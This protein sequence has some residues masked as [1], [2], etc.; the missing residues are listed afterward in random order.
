MAAKNTFW[1][2]GETGAGGLAFSYTRNA[3]GLRKPARKGAGR[4]SSYS[5]LGEVASVLRSKGP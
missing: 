2:S 5:G 1:P 3:K 4:R